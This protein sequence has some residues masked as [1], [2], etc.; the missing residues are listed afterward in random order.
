MAVDGEHQIA[1]TAAMPMPAPSAHTSGGHTRAGN[2]QAKNAGRVV[3]CSEK[4]TAP[5]P[6]HSAHALHTEAQEPPQRKPTP[7][8]PNLLKALVAALAVGACVLGYFLY[9]ETRDPTGVSITIGEDT[10]SIEEQ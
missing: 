7:M 6:F 9:Q 5:F 10:L 1:I 8:S 2:L 4:R 3:P